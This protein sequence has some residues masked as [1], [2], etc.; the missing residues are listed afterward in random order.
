MRR[1]G[2]NLIKW[3]SNDW[4]VLEFLFIEDGGK[5]VKEFN[6]SNDILLME[7]VLGVL[8][9]ME[10]D[11]FGCKVFVKDWLCIRWGIFLVGG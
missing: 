5:G 4:F 10:I 7:R 8:W 2:F 9:F 11:M 6:F 1:G 3:V